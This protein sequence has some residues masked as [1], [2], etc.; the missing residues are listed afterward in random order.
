MNES[1]SPRDPLDGA[2]TAAYLDL[3]RSVHEE[4]DRLEVSGDGSVQMSAGALSTIKESVR[5]DARHGA[6][7]QLPPT[8]AGPFTITELALRTLV[9]ATVDAVPGARALRTAVTFAGA[10]IPRTRG[11]PI[12]LSCRVSAARST[13]SLPAL[14]EKVREDVRRACRIEL[15]LE[16]LPIDIHI[17]DLHD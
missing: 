3:I 14:A 5:A 17:E 9:R 8:P 4:W 11:L 2:A 7:V 6:P 10:G 16:D 13:R 15:G 1:T 12:R